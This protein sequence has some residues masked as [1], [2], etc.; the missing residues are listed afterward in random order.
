MRH[1]AQPSFVGRRYDVA[2][3]QYGIEP[4]YH[5]FVCS[6][7]PRPDDR[8]HCQT[9]HAVW[10][11]NDEHTKIERHFSYL[12]DTALQLSGQ[13]QPNH[14]KRV[15][16]PGPPRPPINESRVHTVEPSLKTMS[17]VSRRPTVRTHR[18]RSSA[19]V[20]PPT[21]LPPARVALFL[22]HSRPPLSLPRAR[23]SSRFLKTLAAA[24]P[25]PRP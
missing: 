11:T 8:S 1:R 4:L 12:R 16:R 17:D 25:L 20:A 10:R 14:G 22:S 24:S 23:S 7:E 21:A 13:L 19:L 5:C 18:V 3:T 15:L 6:P 2:C 9:P